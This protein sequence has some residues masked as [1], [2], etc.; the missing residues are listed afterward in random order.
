[1]TKRILGL[2]WR[3]SLAAP[4]SGGLDMTVCF[5]DVLRDYALNSTSLDTRD[6]ALDYVSQLVQEL[7]SAEKAL[8]SLRVLRHLVSGSN[9]QAVRHSCAFVGKMR[10]H[11]NASGIAT[12]KVSHVSTSTPT[13]CQLYGTYR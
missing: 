11:M 13:S 5:A 2:L 4:T 9:S 6:L 3:I 7:H 10:N 8:P 1:M 12:T